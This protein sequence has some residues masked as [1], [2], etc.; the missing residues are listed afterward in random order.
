MNPIEA[1]TTS[2]SALL[3]LPPPPSFSFDQ[4]KDV[5]ETAVSDALVKLQKTPNRS[6]CAPTLDIAADIPGLLS[7]ACRPRSKIFPQ[8][9]HYL[10]S[11][12]TLIGAVATERSIELDTPGGINTRVIFVDSSLS[13]QIFASAS[14]SAIGPILDLQ[15]LAEAVQ[16]QYRKWSHIFY[17]GSKAGKE[18]AQAFVSLAPSSSQDRMTSILQSFSCGDWSV[19]LPVLVPEDQQSSMPHYSVAVGGTFDHLHLGHKL[20]LTA[21]ALALEP[22]YATDESQESLLTVGVTGDAL[23][24]NKKYAEFLEDWNQ[25]FLVSQ[26]FLMDIMNFSGSLEVNK[27]ITPDGKGSLILTTIQPHSPGTGV[28]LK[29]VEFFDICGPTVTDEGISALVLSK[30]TQAGGAIVNNERVKKGWKPLVIF[31]VDVLQTGET[32]NTE[33]FESKISSTNIRRTLSKA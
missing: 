29:F 4:V 12:Y 15:T 28:T 8:L 20:L 25:R 22:S 26:G 10:T 6:G 16:S 7:P 17:L 27:T 18:L 9:Q 11:I 13:H 3:L 33:G 21:T 30:E 2:P 32:M 19:P 5:F 24:V 1:V 31:E 23:L 14:R